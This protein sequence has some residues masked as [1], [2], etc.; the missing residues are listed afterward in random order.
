MN[1][2]R[3]ATRKKTLLQGRILF[4]GGRSSVDC[5]IRDMSD[6]GA[7]LKFSSAVPT[8]EHF[9]LFIPN[10]D[11]RHEANVQW[12]RDD[13]VGVAFDRRKAAVTVTEPHGD[14]AAQQSDDGDLEERLRRLEKEV[15]LL[16]RL[17]IEMKAE[18]AQRRQLG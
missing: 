14:E 11:E 17:I 6:S 3:R 4:N 2:R 18:S 5:V 1:D 9:E 7:R 15:A 8:P 16:R 10:R 12:R 13:E